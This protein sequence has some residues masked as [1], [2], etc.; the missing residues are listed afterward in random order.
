MHLSIVLCALVT[1]L[2]S[3]H[4]AR[5]A[6]GLIVPFTSRL[7]EC[8]SLCGPLSDVQGGCVPPITSG[9][10]HKC[11]CDDARMAPLLQGSDAVAGVCKSGSA[12]DATANRQIEEWFASFCDKKPSDPPKD[13][14]AAKGGKNGKSS[15]SVTAT[16]GSQVHKE[17]GP[18]IKTHWRWLVMF[19]FLF[20]GLSLVAVGCYFWRRRYERQRKAKQDLLG[21][22]IKPI[23]PNMAYAPAEKIGPNATVMNMSLSPQAAYT[24]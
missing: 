10:D 3:I 24:R 5:L 4:A 21:P 17:E 8:A 12:C 7:P 2:P 15:S 16:S 23:A 9:V 20:G 1:V 22:A 14:E 11:F 19:V 13:T 6:D 18:W